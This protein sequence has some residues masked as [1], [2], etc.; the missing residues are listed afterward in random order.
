MNEPIF[1]AQLV[2]IHTSLGC[3]AILVFYSCET[4]LSLQDTVSCMI[5]DS[6]KLHEIICFII[7]YKGLERLETK[8]I[9]L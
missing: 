1:F 9:I 3:I 6:H 5:L 8:G 4:T 2:I 7:M